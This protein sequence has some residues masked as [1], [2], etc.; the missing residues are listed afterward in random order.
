MEKLVPKVKKTAVILYLIYIALT[1]LNI[2]FLL[3][4]KMPFFDPICTAFGTAGT[5]G[6][7]IKNNSIAGY[8]PYIQNVCTAFMLLFGVNFGC[9]HLL[10]IRQFRGII[11]N[12]EIRLY[13]G[14]IITATVLIAFNIRHLYAG[15]G[16]TIR[17]AAFQVS[18]IMTTT[19]FSTTDFDLWPTFS[20]AILLLLMM[21]GACAGSTGGGLKCAR[22]LILFKSLR[23]NLKQTLHP[24]KVQ[25]IRCDGRIID[26]KVITNTNI[27]LASYIFIVVTSF[28]LIS[29][30]GFSLTTG[31]SAVLACVNNIG[32][33]F[34]V[35]GPMAN[36]SVF[37][38]LSKLVLIFDMLA[39]RLEIIPMLVLF[40]RSTWKKQ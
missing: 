30:N 34:D 1:V 18:S 39:G 32:P 21:I 2:L 6:F 3:I 11:K 27:Y 31:F 15:T 13:F 22:V 5:G 40:E 37:S 25:V 12:E 7:G 20:K 24:K 4:G 10:L 35:V 19:G 9:Y 29:L 38:P 33:G 14:V 17:H 26:E 28:L 16:E 36:F 8:S 23:R